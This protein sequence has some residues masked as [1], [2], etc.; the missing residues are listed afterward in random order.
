M[1]LAYEYVFGLNVFW[2]AVA[3]VPAQ[4]CAVG[5][6]RLA[7][8]M[9]QRMGISASG[10]ALLCGTGAAMALA[11]WVDVDSPLWFAILVT[12]LYSF[13]T[14]AAGVPLTNAIMDS[15]PPGEEGSAS[16]FRS[17]AINMGLAIGVALVSTV[18]YSTFTTS[19]AEQFDASGVP[20]EQAAAIAEDL[21]DGAASEEEAAI[22]AVPL[23]QVEDIDRM[24]RV[25]MVDGLDAQNWSGVIVS[26]LSAG[27]FAL[28]RRR[29][30]QLRGD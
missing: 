27:A 13:F 5:G 26:L 8:R 30:V 11:V 20:V 7:G 21:R 19:L 4:L 12:C 23:G 2:T 9:V 14:V 28:A 3:M 1:T 6:A 15:A 25:A 10:V 18:V 29:Q 17:A 24:Q 22:Y 16:A